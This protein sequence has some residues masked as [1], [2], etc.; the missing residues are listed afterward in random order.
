VE[1]EQSCLLEVQGFREAIASS[2]LG[3]HRAEVIMSC[4]A[5]E[6]GIRHDSIV[7]DPLEVELLRHPERQCKDQQAASPLV[8]VRERG[9]FVLFE[10]GR[11]V[12][13]A[14]LRRVHG[15]LA[16]G[17]RNGH[18]SILGRDVSAPV[19]PAAQEG[20]RVAGEQRRG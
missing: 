4:D 15:K 11:N 18:I 5:Q 17:R 1:I 16:R 14:I 2:E 12:R 10:N 8:E 9:L 19:G 6:I 3:R 20:I 7:I 13:Q